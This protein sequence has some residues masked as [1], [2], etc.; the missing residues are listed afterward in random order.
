[1]SSEDGSQAYLANIPF[2]F[3][4]TPEQRLGPGPPYTNPALQANL[5]FRVFLGFIAVMVSWIPARLLWRNGEFAATVF[6]VTVVLRNIGYI[7]NAL[8]WRDDNVAEWYAGYGWCDLQ[9]YINFAMDTAFNT[10]LFEIMRSLYSKV[11]LNRTTS[12][13]S[14]E[15]LRKQLISAAVIFTMPAVQV[16]LTFFLMVRRYNISTLVG[17]TTIYHFDWVFFCFYILPTPVF[18]TLAAIL[19]G[20]QSRPSS[21][22]C[23]IH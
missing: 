19:A 15:Q 13:T 16:V 11:G 6:C 23:A 9:V 21:P 10:C 18:V 17:C 8:V 1:M 12:L 20:K 14:S 22:P 5:F 3:T 7:I 4:T 2:G